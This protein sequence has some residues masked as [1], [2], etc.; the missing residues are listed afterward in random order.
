[1]S[2]SGDEIVHKLSS[3][4]RNLV[5]DTGQGVGEKSIILF[6]KIEYFYLKILFYWLLSS[7]TIVIMNVMDLDV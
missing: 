7:L 4:G 1:M 6:K 2:D 3:A 5:A